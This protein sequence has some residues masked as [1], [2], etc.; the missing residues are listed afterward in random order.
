M[1][2]RRFLRC[3]IGALLVAAALGC[4]YTVERA[5]S[6]ASPDAPRLS[7]RTLDNDSAE[8]GLDRL[9]S[10]ALRKEWSLR[11]HFRLVADPQRADIVVEGRVLPLLIRARTLSSVVLAIE[12]TVTLRVELAWMASAG[13]R[14]GR[15]R[16]M[17]P[18]LL[19]ESEIYFASAD[20]EAS[21]K[22]RKEA[23]R[24]VAGLIAERAADVLASEARP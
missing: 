17:S 5:S 23:L 20:L 22:N 18:R 3:A 10:E 7:V 1:E 4:G 19:T 9:M 13:D 14:A 8:P 12:Q 16:P 11:G 2:P 15:R 24:R 6:A 21:R